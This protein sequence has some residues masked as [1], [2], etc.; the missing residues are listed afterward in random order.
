M[1]L[2]SAG[3]IDGLLAAQ[4]APA[5][6]GLDFGVR[7]ALA[8][9]EPLPVDDFDGESAESAPQLRRY[10][11]P[12]V[13]DV[14]FPSGV[15][16][17]EPISDCPSRADHHDAVDVLCEPSHVSAVFASAV[18]GVPRDEASHHHRLAGACCHPQRKPHQSLV[19]PLG[20]FLESPDHPVRAVS[21]L[22]QEHDGLYGLSLR[23]EQAMDW[24]LSWFS[25]PVLEKLSGCV[26]GL[27]PPFVAPTAHFPPQPVDRS[28][29]DAV[30]AQSEIPLQRDVLPHGQ[31]FVGGPT[32]VDDLV[33]GLA[34]DG[35]PV[36]AGLVVRPRENGMAVDVLFGGRHRRV[37]SVVAS[38]RIATVRSR[39][40]MV[41][42]MDLTIRPCWTGA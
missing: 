32:L 29:V 24:P 13:V 6:L 37:H 9:L 21:Q 31:G 3:E 19:P 1:C 20:E 18:D 7:E 40:P 22:G 15:E 39:L 14:A 35:L 5:A 33:A 36:S 11:P 26:A 17:R 12:L 38:T 16:P 10:E 27:G 23:V 2:F 42:S 25:R 8:G 34:C 28:R 4:C 41:H 30:G